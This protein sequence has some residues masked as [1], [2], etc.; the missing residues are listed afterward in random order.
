MKTVPPSHDFKQ[1]YWGHAIYVKEIRDDGRNLAVH[2]ISRAVKNDD[3][4]LLSDGQTYRVTAQVMWGNPKD[5][6]EAQ[7]SLVE[8]AKQ[9]AEDFP[10]GP[11]CDLSGEGGCEACS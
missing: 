11:A 4:V 1:N 2:G 5:A 6:W 10:L 9:D 3:V 8:E 7:L